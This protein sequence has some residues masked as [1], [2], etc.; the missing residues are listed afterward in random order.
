[1]VKSWSVDDQI[2][3]ESYINTIAT[4]HEELHFV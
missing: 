1:M 3:P 2:E 4:S